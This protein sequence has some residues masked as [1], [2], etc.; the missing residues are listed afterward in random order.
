MRGTSRL[1]RVS[2]PHLTTTVETAWLLGMVSVTFHQFSGA[3]KPVSFWAMVG[4]TCALEPVTVTPQDDLQQAA[5]LIGEHDIAHLIVMAD[6]R[7]AG[8]LST[9]DVARAVTR[10]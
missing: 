3:A 10:A 4:A 9:L 6:G 1:A 8:V 2:S 7:P 5:R